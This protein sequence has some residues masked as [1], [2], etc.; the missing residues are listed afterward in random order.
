[1]KLIGTSNNQERKKVLLDNA[2][3]CSKLAEAWLKDHPN[4]EFMQSVKLLQKSIREK[5]SLQM[6]YARGLATL[7][8]IHRAQSSQPV[9]RSGVQQASRQRPDD[10]DSSD[11]DCPSQ[12]ALAKR[13]G[14]TSLYP[15]VYGPRD[16]YG[17]AFSRQRLA[18]FPGIRNEG[19]TCWGN[20]I[21]QVVFHLRSL[22]IRL[23][24][25]AEGILQSDLRNPS[26]TN[27][28]VR[29]LAVF[30]AMDHA[31]GQPGDEAAD[32]VSALMLWRACETNV[33]FTFCT[34]I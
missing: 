4:E 22:R 9:S 32:S 25:V 30:D 12:A 26:E 14:A 13:R 19:A 28:L 11:S 23:R 10:S 18:R 33:R 34:D 27:V 7:P 5:Q 15:N 31:T 3:T 8:D 17:E 29:L 6:G 2:I 20:C 1:M 24:Q 21:L 16:S